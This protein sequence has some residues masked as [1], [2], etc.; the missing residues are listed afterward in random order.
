[1]WHCLPSSAT[2]HGLMPRNPYQEPYWAALE[3]I[4]R[5]ISRWHVRPNGGELQRIFTDGS[6]DF[7]TIACQSLASWAVVSEE[8]GRTLASG[9]LPGFRQTINRAELWAAVV[10]C[11]WLIAY[12]CPGIIFL[13]SKYVL[14][15]ALWLQQIMC[16]PDDWDNTDLWNELLCC[17]QLVEHVTF[18]KV[19]A[20]QDEQLLTNLVDVRCA[21]MNNLVDMNAKIALQTDGEPEL[22]RIHQ[23]LIHVNDWQRFWCQRCQDFLLALAEVNFVQTS[24][25][26][27]RLIDE[28]EFV[29]DHPPFC[30]N[31]Q[32]W[33]DDFP[34]DLHA[35]LLTST[36][37]QDFGHSIVLAFSQ[38]LIELTFSAQVMMPITFLEFFVGYQSVIHDVLPVASGHSRHGPQ[39]TS[40]ERLSL[41]RSLGSFLKSFECMF[42]LVSNHFGMEVELVNLSHPEIGVHRKMSG[43]MVPWPSHLRELAQTRI[44]HYFQGQP[45]RFARDLTR[46]WP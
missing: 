46:S 1:M 40:G 24:T 13:D 28:D 41:S 29:L 18:Q 38:W 44:A 3:Q 7:P 20:H 17:F 23:A 27:E 11:K 32:D 22:R 16:V 9:L 10:A 36:G 30:T 2:H 37:I 45:L 12:R 31:A 19:A 4:P 6:C 33:V 14:D 5:E 35:S 34:L 15:G 8:H 25:D 39:W 21:E 26:P 42:D 43:L